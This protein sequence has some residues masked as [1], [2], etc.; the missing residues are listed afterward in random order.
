[1]AKLPVDTSAS[2]ND[3][4]NALF[5]KGVTVSSATISGAGTQSGVFSNG[6]SVAPGATPSDTGV[7]LST[8]N[9]T[10]YTNASGEVNQSAGTSSQMG[11]GGDAGIN[12]LT[13]GGN[14]SYDAV[15]FEADFVPVGEILKL[16]LIFASEEYL[17]YV[18]DI[19]EDAIGVWINGTYAP[20]EDIAGGVININTV[21]DTTNSSLFVDNTGDLINTEMDGITN[22]LTISGPVNPGVTNTIR[23]VIADVGDDELDSAILISGNSII[24]VCFTAGTR[25][26]TPEGDIPV[27][28]LRAG[29]RIDTLDHGPQ[30]IRW[31]GTSVLPNTGAHRPVRFQTGE[32]GNRAPLAVSQQH[33]ILLRSSLAEILF[34]TGEVFAAAKHLK[35]PEVTGDSHITFFHILL[36]RHE[37]IFAEGAPCE[38]LHMGNMALIGMAEPAI[39]ALRQICPDPDRMAT[40]LARPA[41]R[42]FECD[43]LLRLDPAIRG[44]GPPAQPGSSPH[45]PPRPPRL[46]VVS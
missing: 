46:W 9:A 18:G 44:P 6:D 22:Q 41:L 14:P 20:V 21:N 31:I 19:Y 12:A 37:V 33:R 4:A 5:G 15:V 13:G 38:S 10:D 29:M 26:S 7:I 39:A 24:S 11:G 17:E 3:M 23:I 42:K 8:G 36:D 1:M 34:D 30:P 16:D 40:R 43:A 27:E 2:A 25:I 45:K 35:A 32:I 28:D